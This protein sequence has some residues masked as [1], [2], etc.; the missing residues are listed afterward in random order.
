MLKRLVLLFLTIKL[1]ICIASSNSASAPNMSIT[2]SNDVSHDQALQKALINMQD[3]SLF[4]N[5]SQSKSITSQT[6]LSKRKKSIP[7]K[8]KI[9]AKM[10]EFS[11]MRFDFFYNGDVNYL[12][13]E[14]KKYNPSMHELS[15]L[16]KKEHLKFNI[17]VSN[18]NISEIASSLN[19]QTDGKVNLIYEPIANNAR[20]IFANKLTKN[21]FATDVIEEAKK[22]NNIT[23][24][25]LVPG[26]DGVITMPFGG[27]YPLICKP[28][29]MCDIRLEQGEIIRGWTL[30]DKENWIV[31][32]TT[33]PQFLYSGTDG[34]TTPHVILKPVDAGL[35]S[36][37]IITTN[38]RTYNIPLQS[39]K[40][41]YV[42][43]IAFYYPEELNQARI[44]QQN[45]ALKRE[46]NRISIPLSQEALVA[47]EENATPQP[48]VAVNSLN[49]NYQISG[50]DVDWKPVQAFDDGIHV[51]LK[52]AQTR[53]IYP[54]LF[55]IDAD[56]VEKSLLIYQPMPG[57]YYRV[58]SL[59]NK[60]ALIIGDGTDYE[61]KVLIAKVSPEK[62]WYKR[63][64]GGD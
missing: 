9:T 30:S 54:P 29:R 46:Q 5:S 21:D 6:N 53:Q 3:S 47:S 57:G 13:D 28:L 44:D 62:P 37:L 43:A 17:D 7:K 33:S 31:P 15:S 58:D 14:L 25:K 55:E 19:T 12:I 51:W 48:M 8:I 42:T 64:F 16:G 41:N 18:T 27:P 24:L 10:N 56:G 63:L 2:S 52:F 61:K 1:S 36:N 40:D 11:S 22:L 59:F 32:G 34:N 49:F 20:L 50:D 26:L 23:K 39:S 38:K 35:D 45:E 60:A 4:P